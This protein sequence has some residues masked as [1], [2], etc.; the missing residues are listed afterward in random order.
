MYGKE[1]KNCLTCNYRTVHSLA[2][3][4]ICSTTCT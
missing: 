4:L 2:T 1:I 3:T